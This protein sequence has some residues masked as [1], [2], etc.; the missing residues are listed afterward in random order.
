MLALIRCALIKHY[1]LVS[2]RAGHAQAGLASARL[3]S[4]FLNVCFTVVGSRT[5]HSIT[6]SLILQQM[7]LHSV[8]F[9]LYV[10]ISMYAAP[11]GRGIHSRP[12]PVLASASAHRD[13]RDATVCAIHSGVFY[14]Y[15]VSAGSR[16]SKVA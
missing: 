13:I 3:L 15:G 1:A 10:S 14:T 7:F 4:R 6:K 9:V 5:S 12:R 16:L 11:R 8:I 2:H